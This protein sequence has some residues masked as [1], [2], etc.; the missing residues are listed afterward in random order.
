MEDGRVYALLSGKRLRLKSRLYEIEDVLPECFIRINQSCI[1]NISMIKKFTV[2]I[3]AALMVE[4]KCGYRDY[5][6]RRQVKKVKER[7]RIK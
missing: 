6:S 2:S 5:V 7:L 1:V 4:L 3:G